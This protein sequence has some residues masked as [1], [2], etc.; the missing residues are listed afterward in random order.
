LKNPNAQVTDVA[1]LS[2]FN[3][4]SYFARIFKRFT[5]T[6]PSRFAEGS[7]ARLDPEH[8]LEGLSAQ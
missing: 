2:G 1:Y 6:S 4:P 8:L 5:R 7:E 3:D